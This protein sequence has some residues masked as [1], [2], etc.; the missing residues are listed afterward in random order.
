MFVID[1]DPGSGSYNTVFRTISLG[2]GEKPSAVAVS[3][4]GSTLF[5]TSNPGIPGKVWAIGV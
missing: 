5:V 4:D 3:P 1:T 2:V